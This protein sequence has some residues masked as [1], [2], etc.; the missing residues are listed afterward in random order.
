[1]KRKTVLAVLLCLAMLLGALPAVTFAAASPTL[2]DDYAPRKCVIGDTITG[3]NVNRK[4]DTLIKYAYGFDFKKAEPQMYAGNAAYKAMYDASGANYTCTNQW[5]AE[6]A[7]N[8]FGFVTDKHERGNMAIPKNGYVLSGHGDKA[9]RLMAN[10]ELGDYISLTDNAYR[11]Y[12]TTDDSKFTD[13]SKPLE[14]SRSYIFEIVEGGKE[15]TKASIWSST[16]LCKATGYGADG[17]ANHRGYVVDFG[18]KEINPIPKGYFA[19]VVGSSPLDGD[20]GGIPHI[21]GAQVFKEYAAPGAMVNIGA[22]SVQLLYDAAAGKRA[23]LLVA[24]ETNADVTVTIEDSAAAMLNEAKTTFKPVDTARLESLYNNIAAVAQAVQSMSSIQEMEPYMATLYQNYREMQEVDTQIC[25]VEMRAV[26]WRPMHDNGALYT[27]EELDSQLE[28]NISKFKEYGYN[29]VFV[30]G[31]YNS[32][33]IFPVDPQEATYEGLCYQHNPYL[34]PTSMGG[35]NPYLTEPYDMLQRT[36]E[37]CRQYDMEC[38]LW[39]EVLYVGYELFN[40]TTDK[41]PLDEY[42]IGKTIRQDIEANGESSRYYNWLNVAH[43]GSLVS[44]S[45]SSGKEGYWLNPASQGAREFL[46]NTI[47][48]ICGHYAID[49]FQIDYIRHPNDG[50]HEFGYDSETVAAFKSKYPAYR[51]VDLTSKT[52]WKNA[53]WVQFRADYITAFI[54]QI[55]ALLTEKHPAISLTCSPNPEITTALNDSLQDV[56]AWLE[57][58][59]IDILFPMSYGYHVPG[60][61]TQGWVERNTDRYVCTGVSIGYNNAALEADW[62]RQIRQADAAGVAT[63]GNVI[64]SYVE[65]VWSQ[66]AVT[67]TGKAAYA[68]IRYLEDTTALRV[69]K[70]YELGAVDSDAQAALHAVIDRAVMILRIEGIESDAAQEAINALQTA[71]N[72]LPAEAKAALTSDV[73][74][75]VKIRRNAR[76]NARRERDERLGLNPF[77]AV[78]GAQYMSTSHTLYITENTVL[79]GTLPQAITVVTA[80][81]VARLE[82]TDLTLVGRDGTALEVLGEE[83]QIGLYGE[84]RITADAFPTA[85]VSYFG[86]G[87]LYKDGVLQIRMGDVDDD[88]RITTADARTVLQSSLD[89]VTLTAAQK[90]RTDINGDGLINTADARDILKMSL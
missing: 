64:E 72:D 41:D 29:M 75:L 70:M 47:D 3:T 57:N 68:A 36:I 77:V 34:V 8:E 44:G 42:G 23:A 27:E 80:D 79:K 53:D 18:G 26:W 49:S 22:N 1:M 2:T 7:V 54:G 62:V 74:Q 61:T 11:V 43:D 88:S 90:A 15:V 19:L 59:Y 16:I 28:T 56:S 45:A 84:N 39:W 65:H 81:T 48:Y 46:L 66:P 55:R 86:T 87:A 14:I 71:A 60:A 52:Y 78:D 58:D 40:N 21:N 51:S 31:F 25:S 12:R 33:T 32:V 9:D 83:L 30:E 69:D 20:K 89:I 67:P 38:H 17:K 37:L 82:L 10:I 85:H 5:G 4:E 6:V 24:G 63:F 76:D 35:R 50:I 13:E 73:E